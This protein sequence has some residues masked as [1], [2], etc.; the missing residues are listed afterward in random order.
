MESIT[1][2]PPSF[3]SEGCGHEEINE[4]ILE[5]LPEDLDRGEGTILWDLS[6]AVSLELSKAYQY[7]GVEFVRS[8]FPMWQEDTLLLNSAFLRGLQLRQ[9]VP[10]SG[11]VTVDGPAGTR[12]KKGTIFTTI[13]TDTAPAIRYSS[14]N[15]YII[16]A[17]QSV[18]VSVTC[19][20]VGKNGD[21]MPNTI[22]LA[23]PPDSNFRKITNKVATQGGADQETFDELRQ[24]I[25][26]LDQNK[27]ASGIGSDFDYR[28]WSMEVPG[29]GNAFVSSRDDG[30]AWIDI[31]LVDSTGA[32]AS[33]NLCQR[34][35]SYIMTDTEGQRKAP[36]GP[37]LNVKPAASFA[38]DVETHLEIEAGYNI[39]DLKNSLESEL[40]SLF[41]D[42][43]ELIRISDVNDKI[44][45]L[46]GVRDYYGTIINGST[47]NVKLKKNQLAVCGAVMLHEE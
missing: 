16:D 26:E 20:E 46:V 5:R 8:I 43:T 31:F 2:E 36:M 44:K 27:D 12:I 18:D 40:T 34:V 30:T 22:I 24:R 3:L 28:Q 11:V 14:D 42:C 17:K 41:K 39:D 1:F 32:P 15:E 25:I 45:H 23:D 35:Y 38:I 29:V 7:Y 33:E 4:R 47:S 6:M 10:S 21:T 9:G 37:K 19:T 13:A